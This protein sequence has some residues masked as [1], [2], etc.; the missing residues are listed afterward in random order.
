MNRKQTLTW[1]G[2]AMILLIAMSATSW[3]GEPGARTLT[4]AAVWLMV[5][6]T[7]AEF[8]IGVPTIAR[9]SAKNHARKMARTQ[10]RINRIQERHRKAR[11]A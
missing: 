6:V 10:V 8:W 3:I 9:C 1:L 5:I 11:T 4:R 7:I 2:S